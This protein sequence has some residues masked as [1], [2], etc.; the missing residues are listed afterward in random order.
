MSDSQKTL[1]SLTEAQRTEAMER[2]AILKPVVEQ[3]VSQAEVA[4]LHHLPLRTVQRW[5]QHY[6]THGLAGLTKKQRKDRGLRRGLPPEVV[7]LVEGL[8][9][10][11]PKR[12]AAAIHR[13]VIE[14]ATEQGWW[15]I[16]SYSRV[17]D[18]MAI[19]GQR[20]Q[21]VK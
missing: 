14:I 11:K 21:K 5:M 20:T 1:S 3:G 19:F 4:R 13:H 16:P 7:R 12:S 17:Y 15:P 18:I 10:Q 6:R 2:F 8:A 9:L